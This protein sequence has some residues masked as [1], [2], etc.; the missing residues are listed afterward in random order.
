MSDKTV[1]D[2]LNKLCKWRR[3]FASWQLGTRLE[4]DGEFQAVVNHRELSILLR[5]ELS[6]LT[7]V[8]IA[9][10]A[11]TQ[12]EFQDAVEAEAK[13]LDHDYE[14][15]YPGFRSTPDGMHMKLPEAAETMKKMGFPP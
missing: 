6:A 7:A 9:K 2:V 14:E 10:G 11:F 13:R 15:A 3:F 8:L 4:G 5:A 12:A 1:T